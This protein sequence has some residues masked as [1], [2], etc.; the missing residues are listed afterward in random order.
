MPVCNKEKQKLQGYLAQKKA[1]PLLYHHLTLGIS[2]CRS[3]GGGRFLMSGVPL[4][5]EQRPLSG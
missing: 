4:Y 5:L 1:P 2:Y 3:L